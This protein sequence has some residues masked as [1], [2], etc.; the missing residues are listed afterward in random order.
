MASVQDVFAQMQA[1]GEETIDSNN[2]CMLESDTTR[3]ILIP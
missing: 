2:Y 1:E 3:K